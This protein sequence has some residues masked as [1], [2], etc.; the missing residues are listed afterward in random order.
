M[1]PD[2]K[3]CI[4]FKKTD[5]TRNFSVPPDC[6]VDGHS[7][8]DDEEEEKGTGKSAPADDDIDDEVTE[9]IIVYGDR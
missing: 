5:G 4:L 7:S 9:P 2:L 3:D 1:Q 8:K 6:V